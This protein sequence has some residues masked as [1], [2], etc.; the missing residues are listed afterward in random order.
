MNIFS[1]KDILGQTYIGQTH[2][3]MNIFGT[4]AFLD[5]YESNIKCKPKLSEC[6]WR[7][8]DRYIMILYNIV[9]TVGDNLVCALTVSFNKHG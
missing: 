3:G 5:E 4:N 8:G 7:G 2:F 6:W 9:L 1:N